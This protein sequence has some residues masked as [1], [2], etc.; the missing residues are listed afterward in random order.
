M[1]SSLIFAG[2]TKLYNRIPTSKGQ[3][4]NTSDFL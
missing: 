3:M 2:Y 1:L 4:C